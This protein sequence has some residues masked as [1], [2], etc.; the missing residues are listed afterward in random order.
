MKKVNGIGTKRNKIKHQKAERGQRVRQQSYKF[1]IL[2]VIEWPGIKYMKGC[3]CFSY[4]SEVGGL[5]VL[6]LVISQQCKIIHP[7]RDGAMLGRTLFNYPEQVGR[8]QCTNC[9][10]NKMKIKPMI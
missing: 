5:D 9:P 7:L 3:H 8:L 1:N 6:S 2:C 10:S 4:L